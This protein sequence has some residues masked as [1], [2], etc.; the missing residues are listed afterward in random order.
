MDPKIGWYQPEQE[1]PAK[2]FWT[3]IWDAH[4]GLDNL[5]IGVS[6]GIQNSKSTEINNV[7]NTNN[8]NNH[9]KRGL[10]NFNNNI[11]NNY[12]SLNRASTYA[13]NKNH[14]A[15]TGIYGGCPWR[16]ANRTYDSK[17]LIG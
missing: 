17:G 5:K 6:E 7:D 11:N 16:P 4:T 10:T 13:M 15:L 2:D 9:V 1:G 8:S 3:R 12:F 14:A